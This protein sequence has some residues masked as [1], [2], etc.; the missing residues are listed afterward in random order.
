MKQKSTDWFTSQR[1]AGK[2]R[3][4]GLHL[5]P[6]CPPPLHPAWTLLQPWHKPSQ[7]CHTPVFWY[8][9]CSPP[10]QKRLRGPRP[11]GSNLIKGFFLCNTALTHE[12]T[13][14]KSQQTGPTRRTAWLRPILVSLSRF[15]TTSRRRHKAAS[16]FFVVFLTRESPKNSK[17]RAA[18]IKASL[19]E[20]HRLRCSCVPLI[21]L[22]LLHPWLSSF[23]FWCKS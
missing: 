11:P 17:I 9:F 3:G 19:K 1:S 13:Q 7:Q 6:T 4:P 23:H 20:R 16:C 21:M 2:R 18:K 15:T 14:H 5:N 22:P 10:D 8:G 12:C